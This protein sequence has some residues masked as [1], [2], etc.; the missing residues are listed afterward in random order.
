VGDGTEREDLE[1]FADQTAGQ[2][3]VMPPVPHDEVWKLLA[4]AHVGVLPFPDK[5]KF[6]VSSPIKLFEYMAAGLPILA[7]RIACHT[8]VVG[9][10]KYAFWAEQA[11]VPGL[12]AGL[13]LIWQD[14]GSLSKMGS[15]AATAAEAWTWRTSAQELKRSLEYGLATTN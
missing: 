8:D 1:Q 14:R 2:I 4:Q 3:R 10:T 15:Q 5:E 6:Q 7:T 11:D 12:L 9:D 13:R